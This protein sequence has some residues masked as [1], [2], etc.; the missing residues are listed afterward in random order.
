MKTKQD[1]WMPL[2]IR[3][4][5][6]DTRHLSAEQHGHY[7]LAIMVYW[8]A[9]GPI[10]NDD[11]QLSRICQIDAGPMRPHHLEVLRGFFKVVNG[12][13]QHGRIDRELLAAR[14]KS[15][16]ARRAAGIKWERNRNNAPADA[17]ACPTADASAC[18]CGNVR[19]STS[20]DT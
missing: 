7:L 10:S 16:Q 4:Y 11:D 14:E 2:Y 12:K 20:P 15:E 9:G 8:M 17:S 6:A 13:L 3:D 19:N 5:L 18:S 1:I